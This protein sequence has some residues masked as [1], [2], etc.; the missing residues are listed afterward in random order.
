MSTLSGSLAEEDTIYRRRAYAGRE[1]TIPRE[2]KAHQGRLLVCASS[3]FPATIFGS[4]ISHYT[5]FGAGTNDDDPWIYTI[6]GD[7]VGK[8]LWMYVTDQLYLGTKG[9]IFAV[10]SLITP[11]QFLLR[12]VNSHAASEIEGVTAAGSLLYFQSDK[13][14]IREVSYVDQVE[15]SYQAMDLTIF[16][17]HLFETYSAVKMV[18]Q[19]SP[20]TII[21][22]L[23][24]DGVLVSLSYEKTTDMVAFARHEV[25]GDVID[26]SGGVGD[27][28]YAIVERAS[29]TKLLRMGKTL[30]IDG[31]YS[32][33][34]LYLD[35]LVKFVMGDPASDFEAYVQND[36]FRTWLTGESITSVALMQSESDPID[37]SSQSIEGY[38]S[39]CAL[40]Q[41]LTITAIDLS[42]NSL[43]TWATTTI[44]ATWVT[45]DFSN[46]SF[47][48]SDVNQI[49]IDV[50]ASEVASPRGGS[51]TIDLSTNTAATYLGLVAAVALYD[52]G[53]TVTIDNPGTWED[54]YDLTYDAN[55]GTGSPPAVVAYLGGE[56]VTIEDDGSLTRASYEFN[57]WNTLADGTGTTY[58]EDENYTMPSADTTLYAVWVA[59]YTVAYNGNG[60]TGG[61][62]PSTVSYQAGETITV[63]S[64]SATKTGNSFNIWNTVSGGTGTDRTPG[65]TF[66]MPASDVI[67]YAQWDAN[68]YTV[69]FNVNGGTGSMSGQSI[70]YDTSESL[71]TNTLTRTGYTFDGWATTAG[72]AVAYADGA[73]YTM[74]TT[75]ATL[76][77]HW[78]II[79][80]TSV[81]RVLPA[82]SGTIY[83]DTTHIT[84]L[85]ITLEIEV[86]P[87]TVLDR[88]VTWSKDGTGARYVD[89]E[90][91]TDT[92]VVVNCDYNKSDGLT[93][94]ATSNNNPALTQSFSITLQN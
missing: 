52:A 80:A 39:Q 49:L 9:G 83:K 21:W 87:S 28:L 55:S 2:I 59:T 79:T 47:T 90:S 76:Y 8:I 42:D 12:K 73:S 53:W 46:N 78:A 19:H 54:G 65:T 35:G 74:S 3:R 7:R 93:V 72:G 36:D 71:T 51:P 11:N 44:P 63:S 4:E 37:A 86:L 41:F 27:D 89:L 69:T 94:K 62:V 40:R 70:T 31:N 17:T 56:T 20:H 58:Q 22:I 6:S 32:N 13:K 38:A 50:A 57:G 18:V 81:E 91:I 67:L 15:N 29:D 48:A 24:S 88:S 82:G 26:I 5:K 68:E 10:N 25:D 30:L 14:T 23:R 75:G 77:A 1:Q 34:S 16:S 92:T 61:T 45:I 64:N 43:T 66:Q 33:S 60:S 85:D 84:D